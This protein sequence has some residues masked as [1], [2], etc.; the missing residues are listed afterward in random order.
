MDVVT[1]K[2][3]KFSTLGPEYRLA[4]MIPGVPPD[5][6]EKHRITEGRTITLIAVRCNSMTSLER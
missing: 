4:Q 6:R 5:V 3:V 2:A 1:R